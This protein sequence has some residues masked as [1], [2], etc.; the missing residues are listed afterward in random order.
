MVDVCKE[1]AFSRYNM[2]DSYKNSQVLWKHEQDLPKYKTEYPCMERGSGTK[3]HLL[4]GYLN[5]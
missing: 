1:I 5:C 2:V 3:S 4:S